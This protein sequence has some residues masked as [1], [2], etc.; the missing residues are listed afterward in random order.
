MSDRWILSHLHGTVDRV[1]TSMEKMDYGEAGRTLYEFAWSDFSDWYI[2][3]SKV[4]ARGKDCILSYGILQENP[5][6]IASS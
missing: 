2:E 4:C 3:A 6:L 1:T 5:V